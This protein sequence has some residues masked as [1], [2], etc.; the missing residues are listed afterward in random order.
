[1]NIEEQNLNELQKPQLNIPAVIG[2]FNWNSV[3]RDKLKD[4]GYFVY[5][6]EKYP[7]ASK[8][9]YRIEKELLYKKVSYNLGTEGTAMDCDGDWGW[10]RSWRRYETLDE[11]LKNCR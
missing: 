5:S 7:S 10:C 8:G 2:S 6:D 11:A 4:L 9:D 1:M 3:E